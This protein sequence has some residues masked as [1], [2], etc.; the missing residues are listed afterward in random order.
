[1]HPFTLPVADHDVPSA[2]HYFNSTVPHANLLN[3]DRNSPLCACLPLIR[4]ARAAGTSQTALHYAVPSTWTSHIQGD[5]VQ[6]LEHI[7]NFYGITPLV[8]P[9]LLV[10]MHHLSV[11]GRNG[12]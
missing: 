9:R 4:W 10:F 11:T 12:A 3:V 7:V 8:S 2:W 6:P 1:M 5:H